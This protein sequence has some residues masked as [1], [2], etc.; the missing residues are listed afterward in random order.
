VLPPLV[1]VSQLLARHLHGSLHLEV[2]QVPIQRPRI[3]GLSWPLLRSACS[4]LRPHAVC[5]RAM[6]AGSPAQTCE[7]RAR[8]SLV[9]DGLRVRRGARREDEKREGCENGRDTA[10]QI[11]R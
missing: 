6:L 8:R 7:R 2:T 4:R 9:R 10:A 11:R 3:P 1:P 5:P